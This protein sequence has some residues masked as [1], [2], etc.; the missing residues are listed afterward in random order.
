MS[1]KELHTIA[2]AGYATISWESIQNIGNPEEAQIGVADAQVMLDWVRANADNYNLDPD[3][4]VVG[5]RS[6]GSIISKQNT[7]IHRGYSSNC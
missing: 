4:I 6:R 2:T 7:T 1:E 3:H 5:G